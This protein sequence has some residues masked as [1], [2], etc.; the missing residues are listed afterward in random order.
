[1][2]EGIKWLSSNVGRARRPLLAN[3]RVRTSLDR[4]LLLGMAAS[5]R[6]EALLGRGDN[7]KAACDR[8]LWIENEVLPNYDEGDLRAWAAVA[9]FR[10]GVLIDMGD[11]KALEQSVLDYVD[12]LHAD[13]LSH[14]AGGRIEFPDPIQMEQAIDCALEARWLPPQEAVR[15]GAAEVGS[16]SL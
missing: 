13:L 3:D 16:S 12:R 11:A 8:R 5:L 6:D 14:L 9:M 15:S 1:M 2:L 10:P 4:Q 7:E